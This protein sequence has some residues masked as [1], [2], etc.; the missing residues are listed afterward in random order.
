V[1]CHFEQIQ[2][3]QNKLGLSL[4]L[5][6]C[7]ASLEELTG[8]FS[9]FANGG[10]YISPQYL[11]DAASKKVRIISPEAAYLITDE[12][13][14]VNRP[15]FP[16]NWTATE[17]M[18]KIAWKTGTS[19]GRRDA[20]S[21]GYNK[22]YTVGIWCGNFSGVGVP[23]LSG[24]NTATPLLFKI[25]NTIDYDSNSD[26]Y[27]PP[28]GCEL[29]QV[30]SESGLP[31]GP[32]CTNLISDYFFP[33]ISSTKVC[34]HLQEVKVAP[35]S[36]L[37]YCESCAQTTGYIKKL[38]TVTVPEMQDYFS[39]SGMPYQVIPPHNPACERIFKGEG[40]VITFPQNNAEYFI[41]KKDP[42][43]LQ[44]T[45]S[46][47]ADVSRI[48]WYINDRFYKATNRGQKQFFVPEEGPVKI[49][50]SDDKGRSKTISIRVKK[51]TL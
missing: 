32:N 25:F 17:R 5:G 40:P 34:G 2:K 42:E 22:D 19:Y 30:C 10:N 14:R 6:G 41:S 11:Q 18:P 46:V 50:C 27:E 21:I 43:P 9:V 35:D 13:S 38:Y 1:A 36:S 33:L 31:P 44:L 12:L 37:S 49:S 20:W 15:D 48:Y 26:W 7:G 4:I 51:V 16:L 24:A 28:Q 45:A 23:D 47:P 29:R 3:D 39:K 8:L